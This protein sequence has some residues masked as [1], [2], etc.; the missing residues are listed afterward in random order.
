M[1]SHEFLKRIYHNGIRLVKGEAKKGL[2]NARECWMLANDLQGLP[3]ESKQLAKVGLAHLESIGKD[4][5]E[6]EGFNL[7]YGALDVLAK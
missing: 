2:K 4:M 7:L 6:N 1:N 5:S 3:R